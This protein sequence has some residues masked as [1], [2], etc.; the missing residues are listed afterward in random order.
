MTSVLANKVKLNS[1]FLFIRNLQETTPQAKIKIFLGNIELST[2]SFPQYKRS[3]SSWATSG[4]IALL[5]RMMSKLRTA[6]FYTYICTVFTH[7]EVI[8]IKR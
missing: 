5:Y 7:Q 4:F 8:S 2:L 3:D 6:E 1:F